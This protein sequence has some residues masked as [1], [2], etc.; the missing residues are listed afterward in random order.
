MEK[1]EACEIIL[2]ER[3]V[4]PMGQIEP[5][6]VESADSHS[7]DWYRAKLKYNTERRFLILIKPQMLGNQI[8]MDLF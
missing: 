6:N 5:Q 4:G 8:G 2:V 7:A 3:R 1:G